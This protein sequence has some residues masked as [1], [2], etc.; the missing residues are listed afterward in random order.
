MKNLTRISY[1]LL[2]VKEPR[3]TLYVIRYT[4]ISDA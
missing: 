4:E 3:Y 2:R 1:S